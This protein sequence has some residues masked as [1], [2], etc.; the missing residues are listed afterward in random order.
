MSLPDVAGS[1]DDHAPT[2]AFV[3]SRRSLLRVAVL[4]AVAAAC[5]SQDDANVVRK[6]SSPRR[7]LRLAIPPTLDFVARIDRAR[8]LQA[9]RGEAL[10]EDVEVEVVPVGIGSFAHELPDADRLATARRS[11]AAGQRV[12]VIWTPF[13]DLGDLYQERQIVPIAALAAR[14]HVDLKAYS[15]QALQPAFGPGVGLLAL[16]DAIAVRQIY[17]RTDHFSEAGIDFRRAGFD[18]EAP[19]LTWDTLRRAA[20]DAHASPSGRARIAF[21]PLGESLPMAAWAWQAGIP[22]KRPTLDSVSGLADALRWLSALA[23][24]LNLGPGRKAPNRTTAVRYGTVGPFPEGT[25][26]ATDDGGRHLIMSG[27]STIAIDSTR[28]VSTIASSDASLPIRVVE[29]PRGGPQKRAV[30]WGEPSGYALMAGAPDDAWDLVKYLAGEDAAYASARAVAMRLPPIVRPGPRANAP[31]D[32]PGGPRWWFPPYSGRIALD[33][34]LA[35]QYRTGVK[36]LDEAHDHGME[37]FR[38]AGT[39][40]FGAGTRAWLA[41]LEGARR[42]VLREGRDPTDAAREAVARS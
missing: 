41:A 31:E 11:L 21:D 8:D 40:P 17:F 4:A 6:P 25:A 24:E 42:A 18:F 1:T 9:S 13:V 35:K 16:P 33:R 3:K 34:F 39:I 20:L 38:T 36:T 10:R 30:G 37:Q 29:L 2:V 14:D 19:N 5:R 28:L 26:A 22:V 32:L 23:R 12:D 15:P 7:I 27:N